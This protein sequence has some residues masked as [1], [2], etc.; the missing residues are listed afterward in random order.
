[1]LHAAY[2][3]VYVVLLSGAAGRIAD[4]SRARRKPVRTRAVAD[5]TGISVPVG[6]ARNL[7]AATTI[8]T[9]S[10]RGQGIITKFWSASSH[11]TLVVLPE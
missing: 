2:L 8:T 4:P 6:L 1:M 5:P 10:G 11:R 9:T 7:T 3:A